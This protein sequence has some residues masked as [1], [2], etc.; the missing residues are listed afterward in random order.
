M[1]LFLMLINSC[2][3]SNFNTMRKGLEKDLLENAIIDNDYEFLNEVS[4]ENLDSLISNEYQIIWGVDYPLNL[5]DVLAIQDNPESVSKFIETVDRIYNISLEEKRHVVL[6]CLEKASLYKSVNFIEK[7]SKLLE[8]KIF[9][10]SEAST[11]LNLCL[12]MEIRNM[13]LYRQCRQQPKEDAYKSLCILIKMISDQNYFNRI[14]SDEVVE[15][16]I[17]VD[18]MDLDTR[19]GVLDLIIKYKG[20][21]EFNEK[22]IKRLP[23]LISENS[24]ITVAI[25]LISLANKLKIP[26]DSKL[27][28]SEIYSALSCDKVKHFLKRVRLLWNENEDTNANMWLAVKDEQLEECKRL[29]EEEMA[30]VDERNI[31]GTTPLW[32]AVQSDNLD[33][34]QLLLEK[35]AD[36]DSKN[37]DGI[38]PLWLAAKG[39]QLEL[40]RLLLERG[41]D[42]DSKNND[43]ITPLWLAAKGNQLGLCRLLLER[44]ADV[45][46]K[47]NDDITPLWLAVKGNK[48]ELCQLLLER[49]ANVNSKNNFGIT[50]L[51]LA[52]KGNQLELCRLLLDKGADVNSKNNGGITPLW[53]AVQGNKLELCQLLLERGADVNSKNNSG[54]TPLW[55]AVQG[56]KLELCQLLLE[57]GAN[58]NFRNNGGITPLQLAEKYKNKKLHKLLLKHSSY[59]RN[60]A[61]SESYSPLALAAYNGDIDKCKSLLDEE[62][63]INTMTKNGL[64]PLH[65]AAQNGHTEVCELLIEKGAEIEATDKDKK[66]ALMLAA[67]EGHKEV[68]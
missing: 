6:K 56:N 66:R 13:G 48:L 43:G 23:E 12:D 9:S 45:D 20:E 25:N 68:C 67:Q 53:L 26:S 11:L 14:L 46:S 39:N 15:K 44:G 1:I 29:I 63:N 65:L 41:A 36:V 62:A 16:I 47:N 3:F 19:L 37:N 18:Y 4:K 32:L 24:L 28:K 42:V 35:G 7:S 30:Y 57:R 54:I 59:F 51:W 8:R 5:L 27:S 22:W 21:E 49:G 60:E 61:E 31:E 10:E 17:Y 50:P 58:A 33:L 64:T 34:C 2:S 52:T 55:L 38:T 40:C